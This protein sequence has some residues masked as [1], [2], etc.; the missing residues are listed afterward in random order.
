MGLKIPIFHAGSGRKGK[1]YA[2][3]PQLRLYFL[4][5]FCFCKFRFP[6]L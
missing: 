1:L 3:A 2:V 4:A 6:C 5:Q